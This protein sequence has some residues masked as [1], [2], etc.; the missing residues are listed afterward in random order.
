MTA[1]KKSN[2]LIRSTYLFRALITGI[3]L[4]TFTGMSAFAATHVQNSAAPLQ[5]SADGTNAP[6]ATA[7]PTVRSRTTVTNQIPTTTAV[8]RTRTRKS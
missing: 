4:T 3:T 7:T 8:P 5:P 6:A 2:A 1:P